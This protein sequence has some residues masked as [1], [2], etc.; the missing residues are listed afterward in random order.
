MWLL[1]NDLRPALS[2]LSAHS[3]F[4]L[5]FFYIVNVDKMSPTQDNVIDCMG[6]MLRSVDLRA[7]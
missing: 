3:A 5:L 4:T 6:T 2:A 1:I 7:A